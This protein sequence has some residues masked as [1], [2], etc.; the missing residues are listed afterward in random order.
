MSNYNFG[1]TIRY[2]AGNAQ[3]GMPYSG[4]QTAELRDG[5]SIIHLTELGTSAYYYATGV[6]SGLYALYIAG[7]STGIDFMV[8]AAGS[9]P[10]ATASTLGGVK[11]GYGLAIDAN[12]LLTSL[13]QEVCLSL[14]GGTL[15][16]SVAMDDGVNHSMWSPNDLTFNNVSIFKSLAQDHLVLASPADTIA[17]SLTSKVTAGKGIVISNPGLKNDFLIIM[18][19]GVCGITAGANISI[20]RTD[21]HNPVISSSG[22]GSSISSVLY[23]HGAL[24][25]TATATTGIFQMQPLLSSL[26]VSGTTDPYNY[27]SNGELNP[28]LMPFNYTISEVHIAFGHVAVATSSAATSPRIRIEF[29][30][31]TGFARTSV[32]YADVPINGTNCGVYN[33]LGGNN[34]QTV[35][36]TGLAI[37]GNMHDL[38]GFQFTNLSS[39]NSQ[40]NALAQ[41]TLCVKIVP[42]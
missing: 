38:L 14:I 7:A 34:F 20:D 33:N 35:S 18:N 13:A 26:N 42:Q 32:G 10:I 15:V 16:G 41:A 30:N 5:S 4:C 27:F 40:V 8:G 17:G 28:Y 19:D 1:I 3:Q 25:G 39:N 6:P 11:V 12:G 31:H 22:G 2:P 36:L 37:K 21:P 24:M 29:F 9:V 23:L